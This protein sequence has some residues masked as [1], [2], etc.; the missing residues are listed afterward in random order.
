MTTMLFY[1]VCLYFVFLLPNDGHYEKIRDHPSKCIQEDFKDTKGVII[2][3]KSKE[4]RQ[5]NEQNEKKM[6]KG[7][8]T[9]YK[10]YT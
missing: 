7:Q 2:I 5:H 3:R 9:I 10:H 6:T 1:F 4:D 8:T